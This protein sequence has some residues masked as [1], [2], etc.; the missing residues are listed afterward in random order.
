M[1]STINA[2]NGV[3][4]GS[5]G[6]KTTADTSGVLALQSNG[7]TGLTLNTSLALGVGSGNSTGTSGQV[8]TSAGSAAAPTWGT[9]TAVVGATP[10]TV[11]TKKDVT[12]SGTFNPTASTSERVVLDANRELIIFSSYSP[13]I[14]GTWGA[15]YDSS[16]DTLGTLTLIQ[17]GRSLFGAL[18]VTTDR[19]LVALVSTGTS[20]EAQVI[21]TSGTTITVG[22]AAA[23]TLAT[24]RTQI[25]ANYNY[26]SFIAV[27]STYVLSY[28]R[29]SGTAL[30]AFTVS[31]TTVTAGTE[32]LLS[33]ASNNAGVIKTLTSSTFLVMWGA[34]TTFYAQ[35]YSVSGTTLTQT[36]S[37]TTPTR[38]G[39]AFVY[40][41]QFQSGQYAV[42]IDNTTTKAAI[43]NIVAGSVQ[44]LSTAT[45]F[46]TGWEFVNT[47]LFYISGDQLLVYFASGQF[48]NVLTN[49]AGTA[50]IGTEVQLTSG[51]VSTSCIFG[52]A[53]YLTDVFAK[54]ILSIS[55]SQPSFTISTG[56]KGNVSADNIHYGQMASKFWSFG[57]WQELCVASATKK[58]LPSKS[59]YENSDGTTSS[60]VAISTGTP[61]IYSGS[62]LWSAEIFSTAGKATL[63]K[64]TLP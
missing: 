11:N 51:T 59:T 56:Y 23:V 35:T 20:L 18:L 38:T 22:T 54:R 25:N 3:V 1:P 10:F 5:S 12:F 63:T 15:V 4:S 19:V 8:L 42:I 37:Q 53:L 32:V 46:T 45:L 34:T 50:S 16:T 24:T 33:S 17:S 30:I 61:F 44:T 47:G 7:T 40:A 28:G 57:D 31:G 64:V 9:P 62:T 27:G 21:S 6:V 39:A 49:T 48:V 60:T 36:S 41:G 26:V 14:S 43:I 58:A 2:D 52:N 55:G 29:S 13:S